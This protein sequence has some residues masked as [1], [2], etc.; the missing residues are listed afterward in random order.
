MQIIHSNLQVHSSFS[1]NCSFFIIFKGLW[2][3]GFST[4]PSSFPDRKSLQG[5]SPH[6]MWS[7]NTSLATANEPG[8][9][10][11]LLDLVDFAQM[12]ISH[13]PAVLASIF[14][15]FF[16]FCLFHAA[17]T[18]LEFSRMNF[19]LEGFKAGLVCL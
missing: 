4:Y 18:H 6:H 14:P 9:A 17:N 11:S 2:V 1:F 3:S 15:L 5:L 16:W 7:F 19:S 10:D 8:A 12:F 13:S